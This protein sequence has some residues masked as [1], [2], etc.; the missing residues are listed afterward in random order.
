MIRKT[1]IRGRRK[2]ETQRATGK[3]EPVG[4]E[5]ERPLKSG[6]AKPGIAKAGLPPG[7]LLFRSTLCGLALAA[8]IWAYWPTLLKIGTAWEREPDY[9]HGYLV[10]PLAIFFLWMNRKSFPGV[11]ST[12]L[13][14]P[15]LLLAISFGIRLF[16]GAFFYESI[17]GWSILFWLAGCVG[18]FFGLP[19]LRWALPSIG[20]LFF[21]I[22]LPFQMEGFLSLPL[23]RIATKISCW[24]LQLIG[25]PAIAEGNTILLGE[26]H[27]EVEQACS[28]LRLFMSILALACAYL[29]VT[30]RSWWEKSLLVLSAIPIAIIAN[31]LRIVATGLLYQYASTEAGKRFSHDFAGWVMIPVAAA[32]FWLVLWYLK[33]LFIEEDLPDV[34]ISLRRSGSSVA[35]V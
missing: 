11:A 34:G 20:F 28:G 1:E 17:D 29:I 8:G 23:Q 22:P 10:I 14:I 25:Q 35:E 27:L 3:P 7:E 16:S 5:A 12:S 18:L 6:V 26:H 9:S 13:W 32:M 24:I 30:R 19:T 33:T 4:A 15:S 21:M 31:S 2:Q